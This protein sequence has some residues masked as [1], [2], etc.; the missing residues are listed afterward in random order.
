[1]FERYTE[2]ARRVIFFARYEAS[3]CGANTIGAE[4]ILLGLL[5]EDKELAARFLP[6]GGEAIRKRIAASSGVQPYVSTHVD[7]P[8]AQE[9]KAA[10]AFAAEEATRLEQPHIGTAHLLLGLLRVEKSAVAA[11]LSEGGLRLDAVRAELRDQPLSPPVTQRLTMTG[12]LGGHGTL[13]DR[14]ERWLGEIMEAG[15][16]SGLFT[17]EE[18]AREFAQVAA[19][20]QWRVEAEALLR[21]LA[22]KGLVEPDKLA[23]LP[24]VWRDEKQLADFSAR[25]RQQ[26]ANA[27]A[28]TTAA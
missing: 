10:L 25:L 28:E 4:H 18:L 2:K 12:T 20:R 3:Q 22:A 15:M 8:L 13:P 7:L 19:L 9:A 26:V 24:V 27:R 14:D 16:A 23:A 11:W 21:L 1:M 17:P 6:A 5:R